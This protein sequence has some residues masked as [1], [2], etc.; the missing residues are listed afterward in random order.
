MLAMMNVF[1]CKSIVIQLKAGSRTQTRMI[2]AILTLAST[3]LALSLFCALD[4]PLLGIGFL[5]C[6]WCNS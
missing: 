6:R 3:L 1:H 2:D 5:L 4:A